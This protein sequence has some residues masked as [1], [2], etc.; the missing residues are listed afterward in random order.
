[1]KTI[2][3]AVLFLGFALPLFA[4]ES[5]ALVRFQNIPYIQ[6]GEARQQLDIVLPHDY[7]QKEKLPVIVYIHGGGWNQGDKAGFSKNP[8]LLK[9]GYA[10]VSI[11]YRYIKQAFFPAQIEDCK[12]AIRW[13]RA[14]AKEYHLDAD[15]IGVF[16]TSA[17]GHLAAML[18]VTGDQ[19]DLDVGEY[20]DQSSAVQAVCN[21]FGPSDLTMYAARPN[22]FA[23]TDPALAEVV[24]NQKNLLMERIEQ[25]SPIRYLEKEK[26]YPPFLIL[27]GDQDRLVPLSLSIDFEEKMKNLEGDVTLITVTGV[28]HSAEVLSIEGNFN[29]VVQ[30]FQKNLQDK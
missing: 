13:I 18:G 25:V 5:N 1:M 10:A 23:T 12:A 30:F 2:L 14:H 27:H 4:Q 17:G 19:K 20:L 9:Y 3:Q 15:R 22:F 24:N 26:K 21:L 6:G 16:G 8:A 11:N 29:R 7:Q 28:G